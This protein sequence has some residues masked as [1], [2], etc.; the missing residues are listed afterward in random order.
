MT[1]K[2]YSR[3]VLCVL[4]VLAAGCTSHP[5]NPRDPLEPM[6]REI[7]KFNDKADRYV[8][9]PVA[10]TYRDVTPKGVR[11]GVSNFFSN[12]GDAS[13]TVNYALQA[14]PEASFY[15]FSRFLLN[16]TVGVLGLFDVTGE[17]QRRFAKT[18]FGDTF[19]RWGWKNS[20]YFVMPLM[21]PSTLR[22]STGTVSGM[23]FQNNVI[24]GHPHQDVRIAS[25]TLSALSTRERLLGVEDTLEKA[26]LDPYA[27]MRDGWLQYR[28]KQIG[29][30]SAQ[31]SEEEI[32]IDDLV[33]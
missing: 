2:Y 28:A 29:D 16:T 8:M 6:N 3:G 25:G 17:E 32:D 1:R 11:K 26:A 20:S 5:S 4:L 21:G 13:S 10:E 30:S 18:G 31:K 27:Y 7:Y 19:A 15:S 9:K 12:L 24:Y 33:K 23:A 14:R 22:D